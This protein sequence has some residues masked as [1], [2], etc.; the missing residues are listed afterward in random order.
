[1]NQSDNMKKVWIL[2]GI[3][4]GL[5][6]ITCLS[7]VF[8]WYSAKS[9]GQSYSMTLVEYEKIHDERGMIALFLLFPIIVG[10]FMPWPKRGLAITALVLSIFSMLI[11][12]MLCAAASEAR[13]GISGIHMGI[14]FYIYMF[15]PVITFII[16]IMRMIYLG[17]EKRARMY[18]GQRPLSYPS[19][20]RTQMGQQQTGGFCSQ[21]GKPVQPGSNFCLNCG[22]PVKKP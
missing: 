12:F 9:M 4:L 20:G 18:G 22:A 21:C 15:F 11:G 14:G 17:R 16:A 7:V 2:T 10:A 3:A 5:I 8:T 6:L 19:V 13:N 1:M